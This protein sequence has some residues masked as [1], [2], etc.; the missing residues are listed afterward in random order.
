M[1]TE[2]IPLLFGTPKQYLVL[3]TLGD[4]G[5]LVGKHNIAFCQ[6]FYV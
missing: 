6:T 2:R 4:M 5:N 3:Q 1:A